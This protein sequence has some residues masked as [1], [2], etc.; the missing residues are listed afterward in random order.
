VDKTSLYFLFQ[1]FEDVD[2]YKRPEMIDALY[3]LNII[4]AVIFGVE[5]LMKW[6]AFGFKK[7]FT[8]LWCLLDFAIVVVSI[9]HE[10]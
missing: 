9:L 6:C 4:F 1:A 8:N 7:Y 2:L 3:W 5:M 10:L